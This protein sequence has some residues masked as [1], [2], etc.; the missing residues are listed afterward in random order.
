MTAL[1]IRLIT[2]IWPESAKEPDKSLYREFE[3]I[4]YLINLCH[5]FKTVQAAFDGNEYKHFFIRLYDSFKIMEVMSEL[6]GKV[7]LRV[8]E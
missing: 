4:I 1:R 3:N 2:N 5:D 7:I 6:T 8:E